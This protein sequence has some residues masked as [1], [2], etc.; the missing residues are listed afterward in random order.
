MA[1]D[2]VAGAEAKVAEGFA[3]DRL[4]KEL[5][6][7]VSGIE[8]VSSDPK[9]WPNSGLGCGRPGTQS[10]QVMTPGYEFVLKTAKGTYRVHAT[11]KFAVVCGGATEWR[12][13]RNVGLPLKNINAKMDAARA[14]LAAQ[15]NVPIN[16]IR[17]QNF[18]PAEWPDNSMDCVVAGEELVR[19]STKGYR[20]A[21][22]YRGRV[23]TYHTD[24]DRVRA[25]PAIA[26]E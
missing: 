24:L 21:L 16:E 7:D 13:P 23:Y 6:I 9:T 18:A 20:I 10:L 15:L 3:R 12:N 2:N 17:T 8:V 1:Q 22:R 5:A 25:C 4:A 11:Q 19:Q 26:A 14:D